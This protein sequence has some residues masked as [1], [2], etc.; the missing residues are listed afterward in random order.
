MSS[1]ASSLTSRLRGFIVASVLFLVAWQVALL[2]AAPRQT[3]IALALYGFVF[4]M[5]FGKAYALVPSYFDRT[6]TFPRVPT[7][8]LVFT[9]FGT[10]AL[11]GA[12]LLELPILRV[13]GAVGWTAG[14]ALFLSTLG[15]T[16]RDN[17]TGRE[18]ATGATKG[19]LKP[20][21]RLANAF[22]PVALAYLAAGSY[23]LL[24]LV[25]PLTPLL[26]GHPA[27][28]THLLAAGTATI[29]VFALGM[30]LMPRFLVE[31]PSRPLVAVVLA[32]GAMGPALVAIGVGGNPG[33]LRAGAIVQSVALVGFAVAYGKLFLRSDR[34]RTG[35]YGV[36]AGAVFGVGGVLLGTHFAFGTMSL[37]MIDA[38]L[39][40]NLLGFLGLTIIG[41]AYHFYPPAAG[42]FRGAGDGT[43][44][45]SI[46]FVAGGLFL[47]VLGL[48][49]ALD[50][51][52]VGGRIGA[53]VGVTLYAYLLL[54]LFWERRSTR[55]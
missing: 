17:L 28:G 37:S 35:S 7:V 46:V 16:I 23:E 38:H 33:L 34:R 8:H 44:V 12:P 48:L 26:D 55:R 54:S 5:A 19:E 20:V 45:A 22:V 47:E 49:T 18:T 13:V 32:T 9:I 30:R 31:T 6:L 39:R 11:A 29:L 40:L 15:W 4:H 24:A 21:D 10:I 42:S 43:A 1:H 52:V 14:V 41:V 27:Q 2:A 25:T 3:I 53:L 50:T 36:L 51:L